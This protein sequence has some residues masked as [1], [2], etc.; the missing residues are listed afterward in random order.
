MKRLCI[1]RPYYS[2]LICVEAASMFEHRWQGRM[3]FVQVEAQ[4]EIHIV[5]LHDAESALEAL[6]M[7]RE[8]IESFVRLKGK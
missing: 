6:E 1:V 5:T 3:R 2:S 7:L 8:T 4:P